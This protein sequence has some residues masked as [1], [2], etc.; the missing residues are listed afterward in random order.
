MPSA[1]WTTTSSSRTQTTAPSLAQA[2]VDDPGASSPRFRRS[3]SREDRARDRQAW[4]ER[5]YEIGIRLPFLGRVAGR[6]L[7][8]RAH[9]ERRAPLVEG[10]D[11]DDERKLLDDRTEVGFGPSLPIIGMDLTPA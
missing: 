10:I 6:A 5:T 7:D 11:V 4:I 8:L 9:V 1:S 3:I 2:I